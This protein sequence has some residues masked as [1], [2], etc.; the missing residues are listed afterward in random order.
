[1]CQPASGYAVSEEVRQDSV[2]GISVCCFR[3]LALSCRV[4]LCALLIL[5]VAALMLP[6]TIQNRY[7]FANSLLYL[8]AR[9]LALKLTWAAATRVTWLIESQLQRPEYA[10]FCGNYLVVAG[11]VFSSH[12]HRQLLRQR[13]LRNYTNWFHLLCNYAL[14]V[15]AQLSLIKFKNNFGFVGGRCT[16]WR[17]GGRIF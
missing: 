2:L 13:N 9:C 10:P 16:V 1:M 4:S 17:K 6:A 15:Y 11:N 5:F 8:S 14:G 3:S 12:A 7:L